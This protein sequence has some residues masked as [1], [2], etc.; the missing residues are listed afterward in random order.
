VLHAAGPFIETSR[1]MVDACLAAGCSYLD[2]TGE[3][4]VFEACFDRDS[5]A[6]EKGLAL[7]PGVGFDVVPSDCLAAWVAQKLP[8]ALTLELALAV[9]SSASPGTLKSLL[10]I[11]PRGGLVRRN[12]KLTPCALGSGVHQVR[13]STRERWVVPGPIA[14]LVTAWHSTRIPD[15][16]VSMAVASSSARALKLGWRAGVAF[17]PVL[18]TLLRSTSVRGRLDGWIERNREGPDAAHRAQG[19]SSLYAKAS[20]PSGQSVE[21]W[22]EC[23]EGYD[24]TRQAA[25]SAVTRVLDEKPKGTLTP[26]QAFGVDFPLLV[27]GTRRL[28]AL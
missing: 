10:G 13:F 15:I 2:I 26:S 3:L 6:K 24:F 28:D 23:A 7:I 11:L 17:Q 22:L 12:G 16:T 9:I 14:D 21:A 5:E 1:P 8:T 27:P 20:A 18:R 25:I 19:S 4:P